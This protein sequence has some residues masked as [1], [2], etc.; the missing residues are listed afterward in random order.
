MLDGYGAEDLGD[1]FMSQWRACLILSDLTAVAMR[2][3]R[4]EAA[5]AS[6]GE[7][8]RDGVV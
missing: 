1:E 3:S 8:A 2:P 7:A 5:L 6:L 4:R